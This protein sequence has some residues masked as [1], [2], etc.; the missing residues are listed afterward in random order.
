MAS[1]SHSLN[2]DMIYRAKIFAH[3]KKIVASR[4]FAIAVVVTS[5]FFGLATYSALTGAVSAE[6]ADPLTILI[7]LNVDLVLLLVFQ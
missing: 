3:V 6:G 5:I 4:K 1:T 7:L 2:K